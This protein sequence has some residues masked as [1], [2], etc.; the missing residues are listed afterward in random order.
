MLA[1]R[2]RKR[3]FRPGISARDLTGRGFRLDAERQKK[4][5]RSS[6]AKCSSCH[7]SD[8]EGGKIGPSLLGGKADLKTFTTL[9]PIRSIGG[10]W[11]FATTVWDHINRA[12]PRNQV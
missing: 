12:I 2:R 10:Y 11:P 9:R 4:V 3:K 7:G 6:P 5:P 8:A 1:R